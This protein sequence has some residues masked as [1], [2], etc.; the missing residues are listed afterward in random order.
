MKVVVTLICYLLPPFW[1]PDCHYLSILHPTSYT[2]DTF[3]QKSICIVCPAPYWVF[4]GASKLVMWWQQNKIIQVKMTYN[5]KKI[6][7]RKNS[8]FRF[9]SYFSHF[10]VVVY[11]RLL[12]FLVLCSPIIYSSL[13]KVHNFVLS[14]F[15]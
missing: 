6:L 15:Y 2:I 3:A 10:S 14:H 7:K 1:D 12:N 13:F 9:L 8:S 5:V 4:N 11:G